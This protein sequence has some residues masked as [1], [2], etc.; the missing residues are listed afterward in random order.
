MRSAAQ[1]QGRAGSALSA[2]GT[3]PGVCSAL[4]AWRGKQADGHRYKVKHGGHPQRFPSP[5]LRTAVG[6]SKGVECDDAPGIR[7]LDQFPSPASALLSSNACARTCLAALTRHERVRPRFPSPATSVAATWPAIWPRFHTRCAS[8]SV[9]ATPQFCH[10]PSTDGTAALSA[11]ACC[12]TSSSHTKSFSRGTFVRSS[13]HLACRSDG[14]SAWARPRRLVSARM[15]SCRFCTTSSGTR[16]RISR[17]G[18]LASLSPSTSR[19]PA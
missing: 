2:S 6:R 3:D 16:T 4:P 5:G 14:T 9:R 18:S 13:V 12:R 1:G 7:T 11:S 17:A 15:R 19:S 8:T 10:L